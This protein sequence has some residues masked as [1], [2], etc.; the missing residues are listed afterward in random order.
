MGANKP[1]LEE[2]AEVPHHLVDLYDLSEDA[3]VTAAQFCQHAS[4]AIQ[5][6]LARGIVL[7]IWR[8]VYRVWCINVYDV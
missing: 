6:I 1:S 7:G 2:Q 8:K 4:A 5:D 3:D